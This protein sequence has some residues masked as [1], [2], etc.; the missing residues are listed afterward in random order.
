MKTKVHDTVCRFIV[1][2]NQKVHAEVSYSE[3]CD[4]RFFYNLKKVS[5]LCFFM[6]I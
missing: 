2:L 1:R 5:H 3:L 4:D 6:L